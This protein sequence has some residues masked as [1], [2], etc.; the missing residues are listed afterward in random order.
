MEPSGVWFTP[1]V[2][3]LAFEAAI[4]SLT[5]KLAEQI[6]RK[7][8]GKTGHKLWA[9]RYINAYSFGLAIAMVISALANLAHAVEFGQALKIFADWGIPTAVYSLAF[10]GVLPLVSLTFA[11][12][13]SNV[14]DDEDTPNPELI[15]A[16]ARLTEVNKR[17]AESERQRKAAEEEAREF[18]DAVRATEE[19]AN[20][21][22]DKA[23]MSETRANGAESA[24]EKA[25]QRAK[26][27][28]DRFG[29]LG[30]VVK[31]LFGEDKRQ[32]ILFARQTWAKLPNSAIA[33]IAESSPSYV[34]EVLNAEPIDVTNEMTQ[35]KATK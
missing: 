9:Y 14:T 15:E 6:E 13:L 3:A 35:Q 18:R 31:Y 26:L 16:K 29:A 27:A 4:A 23:R 28:E 20:A 30:D 10:G 5:Y 19:R 34:S 11:K 32:R 1:W 12:V 2:A 22:E 21:A 7:P 24:W 25:E 33:V 8:K 17:F